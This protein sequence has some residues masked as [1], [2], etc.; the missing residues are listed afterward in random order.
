MR[1]SLIGQ[2]I[3]ESLL[4]T[5]LAVA[6]ALGIVVAVL[7]EFNQI[8]QKQIGLPFHQF[9]FWLQLAGITLVTGL[10]AGSYPALFLSSF[11]PVKVLKGALKLDPTTTI[12]RKGLVVFQF[13]LSVTLITGT[14]IIS[15]QIN[16]T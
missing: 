16:Y 1:S 14:I 3:S 7:P 5:T 15:R 12:F 10:I 4:T 8:T 9:S 11:N 6:I 2:F 13:V